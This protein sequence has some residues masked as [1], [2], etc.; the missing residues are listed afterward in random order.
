MLRMESKSATR[1]AVALGFVGALDLI[2]PA[3][4]GNPLPGPLIGA[5]LPV[6]LILGGAYLL[7]RKL[8]SRSD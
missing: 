7:V 3:F 8:R 1:V 2:E 6:L 4:A 5:G